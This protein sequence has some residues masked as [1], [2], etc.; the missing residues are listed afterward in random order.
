MDD[1][2]PGVDWMK[3][4]EGKRVLMT[5][6]DLQEGKFQAVMERQVTLALILKI[7]FLIFNFFRE[8]LWIAFHLLNFKLIPDQPQLKTV[9]IW[10]AMLML[11]WK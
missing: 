2:I 6:E 11:R 7:I 10:K 4:T 3:W 1:R 8:V 9:W 5:Q